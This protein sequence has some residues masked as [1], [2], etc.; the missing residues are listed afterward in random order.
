MLTSSFEERYIARSN[1]R[2]GDI[3]QGL[4]SKSKSLKVCI[5]I[6]MSVVTLVNFNNVKLV[7]P[8]PNNLSS[9]S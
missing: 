5:Q 4:S 3:S 6:V 8:C 9:K 2:K 1:E 7:S